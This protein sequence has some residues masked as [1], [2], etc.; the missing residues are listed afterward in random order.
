MEA[1]TKNSPKLGYNLNRPRD[2]QM[3]TDSNAI[4]LPRKISITLPGKSCP[5]LGNPIAGELAN[6]LEGGDIG[7]LLATVVK[8][9]DALPNCAC[10]E[11]LA[12]F[13]ANTKLLPAPLPP[14]LP[15]AGVI[16][17][18]PSL[19][20]VVAPT[21]A[22]LLLLAGIVLGLFAEPLFLNVGLNVLPLFV[23]LLKLFAA[24]EFFV[25]S[26]KEDTIP[27]LWKSGVFPR[28]LLRSCFSPTIPLKL[29]AIFEAPSF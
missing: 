21:T 1:A 16:T 3:P 28:T 23:K 7:D 5:T 27:C 13:E 6:I 24:T 9:A 12:R 15:L 18:L 10:V 17:E 22:R 26:G 29:E 8:S 25:R 11:K 4:M 14:S 20:A 19:A 2:P